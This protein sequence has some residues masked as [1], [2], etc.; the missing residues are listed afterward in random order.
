MVEVG[1]RCGRGQIEYIFVDT[2]T[3]FWGCG[4]FEFGV[5]RFKICLGEIKI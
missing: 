3:T 4:K 5:G 1:E 2:C